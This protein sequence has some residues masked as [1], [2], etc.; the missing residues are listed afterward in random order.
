MSLVL[1]VRMHS[2]LTRCGRLPIATTVPAALKSMKLL[3]HNS[4]G[5]R[6]G[7][8]C[9]EFDSGS[10]RCRKSDKGQRSA[11]AKTLGADILA[12]VNARGTLVRCERATR[13][14]LD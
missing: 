5:A 10:G 9:F 11:S 7:D 13:G 12:Q 2:A 4:L 3:N 1:H 6:N 8:R 14:D